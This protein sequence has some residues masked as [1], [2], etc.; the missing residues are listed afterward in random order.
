M[1]FWTFVHVLSGK[2]LISGPNEITYLIFESC[3]IVYGAMKGHRKEIRSH[4]Q[5]L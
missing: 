4:G 1:N 3:V 5:T 2:L